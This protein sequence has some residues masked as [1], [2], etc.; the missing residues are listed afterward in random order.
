[1]ALPEAI[2]NQIAEAE[3]IQQQVYGQAQEGVTP[4]EQTAAPVDT[5]AEV[6]EEPQVAEPV[7]QEVKP[8]PAPE[9]DRYKTLKGKYD[10]EVPRLHKELKEREYQMRDM[11]RQMQELQSRLENV[12]KAPEP[13]TGEPA[14]TDKDRE[15]FGSDLVEMVERIA[16][17][18]TAKA[19]S[20]S[21]KRI[22]AVLQQLGAVQERVQLSEADKFWGRVKSLVADWEQVDADE[23]WIAFLDT[24]PDYTTETYR[25]L[26]AKAIQAGKAEAV[27]KL[28]DIWRGPAKQA[29]P[30]K[31]QVNPDLQRQ[32]QPSSVKSTAP[33]PAAGRIISRQEYE[34]LYDV[35]NVQRY[36][37]K[38]AA[39]MQ[40]EA[41]LAVAEGRVHW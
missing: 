4:A 41:D 26:A 30:P 31:P 13:K 17:S 39:E 34:S 12:E 15:D 23:N 24:T 5:S 22:T 6:K 11:Y 28:V 32:V 10:A 29:E 33:A 8:E 9:D 38:K 7:Q 21:E 14:A 2:Q 40:A 20:E 18:A 16:A 3:A 27:A 37:H 35:R 25:E 36:G 1:M 19:V